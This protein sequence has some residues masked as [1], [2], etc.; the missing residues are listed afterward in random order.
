MTLLSLLTSSWSSAY[1]PYFSLSEDLSAHCSLRPEWLHV[2]SQICL[3]GHIALC[4]WRGH[5]GCRSWYSVRHIPWWSSSQLPSKTM[6]TVP[7]LH[8]LLYKLP[9]ELLHHTLTESPWLASSLYGE[10]W[11]FQYREKYLRK[12]LEAATA[13]IYICSSKNIPTVRIINDRSK[14]C[15]SFC[16]TAGQ[17]DPEL[18]NQS[19]SYMN[20]VAEQCG[21]IS[22]DITWRLTGVNLQPSKHPPKRTQRTKWNYKF[23]R[24]YCVSTK[25]NALS[26]NMYRLTTSKKKK[27][28]FNCC[29]VWNRKRM[30]SCRVPEARCCQDNVYDKYCSHYFR[31]DI[32]ST[33]KVCIT[34]IGWH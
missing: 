1:R 22:S 28:L 13:H 24:C 4:G 34:E 2:P 7:S 18:E 33:Y 14:R 16:I 26:K 17:A 25:S 6:V 30:P 5:M 23:F 3:G 19:R 11:A 12:M 9:H 31:Y 21:I 10:K 29:E 20:C 8:T 15:R 27:M 32:L